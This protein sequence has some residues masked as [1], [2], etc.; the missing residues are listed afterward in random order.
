MKD[1]STGAPLAR[2]Q[3][4]GL[5]EWPAG[6]SQCNLSHHSYM[7]ESQQSWHRKLGHPNKRVLKTLSQKFSVPISNSEMFDYCNSCSSNKS[8]RQRFSENTLV[9][10]KPVQIIFSDVWGP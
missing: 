10:K 8:H 4:K 5:Y 6:G 7:A 3:N 2:G 1:L 9:S